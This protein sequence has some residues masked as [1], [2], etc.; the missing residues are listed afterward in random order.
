MEGSRGE[1]MNQGLD[2]LDDV[3]DFLIFYFFF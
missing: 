3:L 2:D 1:E